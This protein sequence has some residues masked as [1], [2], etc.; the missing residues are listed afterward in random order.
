MRRL[1][2]MSS[3]LLAVSVAGV[4]AP[5]TAD[6]HPR[7]RGGSPP[8]GAVAPPMGTGRL[9]NAARG[10]CLDVAGWAAQGDANVLLWECNEDPDQIWAF[11]PAGEVRNALTGTVLDVSGYDGARGANVDVFRS[12]NLPDQKWQIAPRGDGTFEL[13]NLKRGLCL[14]VN[15]KA[16]ARGDNVML[17]AC[18]GGVDQLWRWESYAARPQPLVEPPRR[19]MAPPTRPLLPTR[20]LP[21]QPVPP[22]P[23]AAQPGPGW[24]ESRRHARPMDEASYRALVAAVR[25]ERFSETQLTVIEQ[26]STRNNF[27]VAQVKGLIE[28]LSFSATKLKALEL[29]APRLVDPENA[30]TVYEAF[31]FS[32]DKEQAR[33]IMRRNGY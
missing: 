8:P 1:I 6:A 3:T 13:H 20:P 32:A 29:G 2:W 19:P 25:N 17:G 31:T 18:D 11:N 10:M 30:F 14:D 9:R 28:L 7:W 23:P 5:A 21:E 22:P 16:G 27:T 24:R 33:Q 15:G 12:E 4:L 26:A